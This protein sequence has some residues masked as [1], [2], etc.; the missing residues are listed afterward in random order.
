MT[1]FIGN[2]NANNTFVGTAAK[3]TFRFVAADI[4]AGDTLTGGDEIDTLRL[5]TAGLLAADALGGMTGVERLMLAEGSNSVTL[6]NSNFANVA[7]GVITV[8]GKAGNDTI[9]GSGLTGTNRFDFRSG[10]GVDVLKGGAGADLFR[11]KVADLDGDTIAGGDG[12]DRLILLSGGEAASGA[13]V[14]MTGV[15]LVALADDGNQL[16]LGNGN[17]TGVASGQI[18]VIGS[19]GSDVVDA[20]TLTGANAALIVARGGADILK[21]G[22]GADEFRFAATDLTGDI[23]QGGDGDDVLRL[24]TAGALAAD[25]LANLSGV[26]TIRLAKDGNAVTLVDG[27]FTGLTG[28]SITV[29]GGSGA[30]SVDGSALTG[31]HGLVI[32]AGDGP[33]VLTGGAGKDKFLFRPSNLDGDT[34]QGG[35]DYDSLQLTGSGAV[36]AAGLDHMSGVELIFLVKGGNSLALVDANFSDLASAGVLTVFGAGGDDTIDGSALSAGNVLAITAGAGADVLKGGAGT[37]TFRFATT[38]LT[39]ADTV[40]GGTSDD[41]IELTTA[42]VLAADALANVSGIDTIVLSS[43]LRGEVNG[44]TLV[45]ANFVGLN[46]API[47]VLGGIGDDTIDGSSLNGN[48][49]L[50]IAAGAGLD[51]LKGGAAE[52][53]F[54]FAADDLFGD[55]ILGGGDN[56]GSDTLELTTAGFLGVGALDNMSGV[57]R[58]VLAA[59]G[60]ALTLNDANM[61]GISSKSIQVQGGSGDDMVYATGLAGRY[62][63]VLFGGGGQDVLRGGNGADTIGG[64]VGADILTGGAGRD[65]FFQSSR[66]EAGDTIT[67]F[68]SGTDRLA[69]TRSAFHVV[70]TAGSGIGKVTQDAGLGTDLDLTDVFVMN[71]TFD[72]AAEVDSYVA[73]FLPTSNHGMFALAH[74][75]SGNNILYYADDITALGDVDPS[76]IMVVDFGSAK[77]DPLTDILFT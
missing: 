74:N 76:F 52:D 56:F 28:S 21:G 65:Y 42:G 17:L 46:F 30:N 54:Q 33:D 61:V 22:A 27:N 2:S 19:A 72:S 6:A 51:V 67:D 18:R 3:D 7:G 34:I 40:Q 66:L 23:V 10:A 38:D 36:G 8:F 77:F 68:E 59:G 11:F 20:S 37:D 62:S 49:K 14:N 63:A 31:S 5:T 4:S 45:D 44:V 25:A 47:T 70:T 26:E 12:F 55:V 43:A 32:A 13:L 35:A 75:S 15:E 1:I 50:I 16:V 53:L 71:G 9:D 29:I 58:I 24:S 64:Q 57:E 48:G 39:S 69:L 73:D 60:C 41:R